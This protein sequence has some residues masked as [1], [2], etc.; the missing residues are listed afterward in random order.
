MGRLQPLGDVMAH[1]RLDG[2]RHNSIARGAWPIRI[3]AKQ[4]PCT[5]LPGFGVHGIGGALPTA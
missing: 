5:W 4:V 3:P 1:G 2:H